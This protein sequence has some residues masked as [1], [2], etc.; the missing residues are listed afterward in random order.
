MNVRLKY[1]LHFNAGVYYRGNTILNNYSLRL[2]MITNTELA[3]DQNTAFERIKYFVYN[4]VDN[5]MFID[6]GEQEQC[7]KFL[8]AGLSI[9]TMPGDPVDQLIGIML[10]HKLNA[11]MEQRMNI[12][13]TELSSSQG[14]AMTYLHSEGENTLGVEA[15]AWWL[16]TDL[17]HSDFA[18]PESEKVVSMQTTTAWRDLD[19]AWSE[20]PP[21]MDHGNIV[22]FADF[23]PNNETK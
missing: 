14:Q 4:H 19:L 22:V 23:K 8:Q 9:T 12:V 7:A 16:S 11:I 5:T 10:Y 2:W 21:S 6:R 1:D 20:L 17:A 3:E 13:E 15:P 18:L